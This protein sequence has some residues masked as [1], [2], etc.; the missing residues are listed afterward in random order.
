MLTEPFNDLILYPD[1]LDDNLNEKKDIDT[2]NKAEMMNTTKYLYIVY[3]FMD[4]R[5]NDLVYAEC[6]GLTWHSPKIFGYDPSLN[7]QSMTNLIALNVNNEVLVVK[8]WVG[9][10]DIGEAAIKYLNPE[11]GTRVN[12]AEEKGNIV[13]IGIKMSFSGFPI[14][15]KKMNYDLKNQSFGSNSDYSNDT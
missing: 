9:N 8:V 13:A 15:T 2:K 6:T 1:T 12:K 3:Q 4:N 11:D 7:G 5:K 10:T 14:I